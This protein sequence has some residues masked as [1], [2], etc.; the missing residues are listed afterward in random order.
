MVVGQ[1]AHVHN[2]SK[3][4]LES[5]LSDMVIY[6]QVVNLDVL[7]LT[8]EGLSKVRPNIESYQVLEVERQKRVL[9]DLRHNL[10]LRIGGLPINDS[11]PGIVK[12]LLQLIERPTQEPIEWVEQSNEENEPKST[13]ERHHVRKILILPLIPQTFRSHH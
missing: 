12:C 8:A 1:L 4:L 11:H 2:A 13:D 5:H 10:P 3:L 9:L 7:E 6:L